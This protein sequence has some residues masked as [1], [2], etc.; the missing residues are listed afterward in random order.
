MY[1]YVHICIYIRIY[2]QGAGCR[3]GG[4]QII[5]LQGGAPGDILDSVGR[6]VSRLVED[7][8]QP[9]HLGVAFGDFAGWG[10][11]LRVLGLGFRV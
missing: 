1:I 10:V 3:E 8:W 6:A 4:W 11:G 7:A 5:H 9:V 2:T